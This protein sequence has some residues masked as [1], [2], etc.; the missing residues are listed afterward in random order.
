MTNLYQCHPIRITYW[1][2]RMAKYIFY[3]CDATWA[4]LL[5]TTDE[6][7]NRPY[8]IAIKTHH[9]QSCYLIRTTYQLL[10]KSMIVIPYGWLMSVSDPDDLSHPYEITTMYLFHTYDLV[11]RP[12]E[13]AAMCGNSFVNDLVWQKFIVVNWYGWLAKSFVCLSNSMP[14]HICYPIRTPY[15]PLWHTYIVVISY[16]WLI[17]SYGWLIKS[18][19]CANSILMSHE[20]VTKSSVWHSTGVYI[21]RMGS[22]SVRLR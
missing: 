20:W 19:V 1:V 7:I 11:R 4:S 15:P 5:L 10:R 8:K 3:Y 6:L 22:Q 12:Y 13:I 14:R 18:F 9:R 21:I 2:I 16:G 17:K